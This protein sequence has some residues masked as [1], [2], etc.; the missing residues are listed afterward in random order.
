MEGLCPKL[1]VLHAASRDCWIE[2]ARLIRIKHYSIRTE[3][4][5][6]LWIRRYIRFHGRRRPR[7]LGADEL[8]MYLSD[9]AV[10]RNVFASTQNQAL[11]AILFLYREVLRIQLP[12]VEDVQRAKKPQRLPVVLTRD[13]VKQILAT[14]EGTT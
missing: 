6:L 8:R 4:A 11:N 9:L 5:Y 14:L 13:E 1:R 2:F 10:R 3:E 7:D 12:W